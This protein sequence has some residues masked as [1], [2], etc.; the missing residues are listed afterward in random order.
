MHGRDVR[1]DEH[2]RDLVRIEV[3]ETPLA[4]PFTNHSCGFLN[5]MAVAVALIAASLRP[6]HLAL[7]HEDAKQ[8]TALVEVGEI[9]KREGLQPPLGSAAAVEDLVDFLD[10]RRERRILH[11]VEE[12]LLVAVVEVDRTLRDAGFLRDV[13]HRDALQPVAAHQPD[14]RLL[15]ALPLVRLPEP[16]LVR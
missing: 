6:S 4:N 15:N 12:L 2:R 1:F 8:V 9:A 7:V 5:E 16:V 11:C 14:H 10:H 3:P 13:V